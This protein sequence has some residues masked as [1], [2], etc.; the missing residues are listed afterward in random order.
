MPVEIMILFM[1]VTAGIAIYYY[2]QAR[3]QKILYDDLRGVV[4]TNREEMKV[5]ETEISYW[6]TRYQQTLKSKKS[7]R[8]NKTK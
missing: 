8:K 5:L 7:V 1:I 3:A 4:E 2:V 6:K